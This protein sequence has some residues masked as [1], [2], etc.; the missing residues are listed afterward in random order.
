MPPSL[1]KSKSLIDLTAYLRIIKIYKEVTF[2][3][4]HPSFNVPFI[5]F[6]SISFI[7]FP[8]QIQFD[9]LECHVPNLS[10]YIAFATI[11]FILA[12]ICLIQLIMCIVAEWQKMKAPSFLR[13]CRITT[14]KVLYFIVFLASLIRGAYFTSPVSKTRSSK[15]CNVCLNF[16]TITV[17]CSNRQHSKKG[18]QGVYYLLTIHLF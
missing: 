18:G 10:Y 8:S 2:L 7:F 14:Q 12:L 13:A 17:L 6:L 16:E 1:T 15:N 9:G 3:K 4:L 11:F 5:I